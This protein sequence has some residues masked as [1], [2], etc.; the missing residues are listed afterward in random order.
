MLCEGIFGGDFASQNISSFIPISNKP[1]RVWIIFFLF[2][3]IVRCRVGCEQQKA[4]PEG[5]KKNEPIHLRKSYFWRVLYQMSLWCK[6]VWILPSTSCCH[7][8]IQTSIGTCGYPKNWH[9]AWVV[10]PWGSYIPYTLQDSVCL[11][12][13]QMKKLILQFK[14]NLNLSHASKGSA[15]VSIFANLEP[16]I[17]YLMASQFI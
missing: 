11:I 12:Q 8:R 7:L 15:L 17:D 6:W 10:W 3:L 2:L 5:E 14:S 4:S 9:K 1:G 13:S 16:L